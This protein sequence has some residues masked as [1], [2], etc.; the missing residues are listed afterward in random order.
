VS[1]FRRLSHTIWHCQ[2]H[3]VWAPKYRYRILVGAVK[4]AAEVGIQA[5]C[6]FAGCE[7]V[8]LNVQRDHVHLVVMIPPKVSVSN[9]V[10]RLKGQTSIKLLHAS[11][12]ADEGEAVLGESF[13]VQRILRRHSRIGC[14]HDT[15]VCPLSRG[16]GE[17]VGTTSTV[18]TG[19][20]C[21]TTRSPASSGGR[22][23][24]PLWGD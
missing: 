6:G 9:L 18:L 12:S 17:A 5:I 10:G 20:N 1:R 7:V 24:S 19:P 23:M 3:I 13:L 16:K 22:A 15:E 4:E 21:G 11:V 8:E 2:Y 14:G